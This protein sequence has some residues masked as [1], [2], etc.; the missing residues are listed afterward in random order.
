VESLSIEL[1]RTYEELHLLYEFGEALTGQFSAL[2]AGKFLLEKLLSGLRAARAEL[3]LGEPQVALLQVVDPRLTLEDAGQACDGH[4]LRTVLRSAG[5]VVGSIVLGRLA[6]DAPFSSAD[7]KLLDAVGALAANALRA[8]GEREAYLRAILENV[9]DGIVTL[10]ERGVLE[11]FNGAAERIFGYAAAEVVGRPFRLLLVTPADAAGGD[12]IDWVRLGGAQVVPN[13]VVGRRKD[14]ATVPLEVSVGETRLDV[15]RL[16]IVSIRNMTERKR[17]EAIVERQ[18]Q[19]AETARSEMRAVLDATGEGI[20]LV[21]PD[22]RFLTVNRRFAELF[23]IEPGEVIGRRYGELQEF[24][25]RIFADPATIGALVGGTAA[26]RTQR[27]TETVVQRWPAQRELELSSTPVE[28]TAGQPLGRLYAFR[29][30]TH[31]REVDRMKSEF[32]ALVSHELRTPLTSI[33]GYA[34][35]LLADEADELTE[36][37]RGFLHVVVRNADRLARLIQDLLDV[38]HIESGQIELKY[39]AV[40]L[41]RVIREVA[42]TFRPQVKQ[43]GQRLVVR[44]AMGLPAVWGDQ[45]RLAQILINLVSNA[46]KYTPAGGQITV[47]ARPEGEEVR[48]DIEDT[49]IGMSEEEQAQLFTRFFRAKNPTTQEAGGTGL[50]LAITRSL[51]EMHGGQLTVVSAP[52]QGSTFSVTLATTPVAVLPTKVLPHAGVMGDD[53]HP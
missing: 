49:G 1:L 10:D 6:R 8:S 22:R 41:D 20:A 51:V 34:E 3:F 53:P 44:V 33:K 21:A 27:F 17:T 15:R 42:A 35:L 30:V 32:V 37:Q 47:E 29:D 50:G 46:H 2:A 38:A 25:G 14:G 31:E 18:Y 48:I 4:I 13:E 24:V 36:E 40:D 52:G 45:D 9:A 43:K 12:D 23:G 7:G 19:A 5:E 39:A 11:S 16:F 28:N 26:D